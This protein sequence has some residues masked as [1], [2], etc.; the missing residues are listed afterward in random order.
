MAGRAKILAFH[1]TSQKFYPGINNI[2]PGYFF[3]ILEL[4]K[5][6]GFNF[7]GVRQYL[8][9]EEDNEKTL[10]ISFDDGYADNY[11]VISRLC[12]ENIAP[13]VFIPTDYIGQSNSWDYSSSL[14]KTRHCTAKQLKVLAQ[15]GA[16][17]GSH[18]KSH[19]AF[20]RMT[21]SELD[22]EL[23]MSKIVLQNITG[24]ETNLLSYP[25]GRTNQRV[26]KLAKECGYRYGF[27]LDS[28]K[29]YNILPED[30]I[31]Y[32]TPIYSCDDYFSLYSKIAEDSPF[33]SFKN[34][35][36]NNLSGGTIITS[37]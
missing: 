22:S 31:I 3:F 32:R 20:T 17:I 15:K 27:C 13:F 25:F 30:F 21:E 34:I 36:V 33:E 23:K 35:I 2:R 14:F 6:F 24:E 8:N 28:P 10:A 1:Q 18:G 5:N 16:V 11:D 19:R 4:L 26:N 9:G 7:I 37:K 12:C 29:S